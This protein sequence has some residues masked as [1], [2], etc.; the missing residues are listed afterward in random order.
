MAGRENDDQGT[1]YKAFLVRIWQDSPT[2][3]WRASAQAVHS[4]EIVRFAS[5]SA[6]MLFLRTQAPLQ[7]P[8]SEPGQTSRESVLS[9]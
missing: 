4:G 3:P 8:D 1:I 5:L 7:I 6:L 9:A 2:S